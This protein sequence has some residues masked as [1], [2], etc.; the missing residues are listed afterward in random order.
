[1]TTPSKHDGAS[2]QN[3]TL[4]PSPSLLKRFIVLLVSLVFVSFLLLTAILVVPGRWSPWLQK[5]LS[6]TTGLTI[7]WDRFAWRGVGGFQIVNFEVKAPDGSL[8]VS[9]PKVP[10]SWSVGV[11]QYPSFRINSLEV[12][13]NKNTNNKTDRFFFTK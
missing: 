8:Y 9:I 4:P 7:T 6:T 13:A 10:F 12:H 3:E 1:M 5:E 11:S 2:E